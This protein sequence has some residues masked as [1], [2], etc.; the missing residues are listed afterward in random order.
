MKLIIAANDG[1]VLDII[2]VERQEWDAAQTNE[3]TAASILRTLE[4]GDEAQ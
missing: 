1:E 2:D 4:P 3:R